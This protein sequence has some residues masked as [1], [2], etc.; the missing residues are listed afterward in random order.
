[1]NNTIGSNNNNELMC[2]FC[3]SLLE[4]LPLIK[5]DTIMYRCKVC[6]DINTDVFF[7]TRNKIYLSDKEL[8]DKFKNI[9][10]FKKRIIDTVIVCDLHNVTDLFSSEQFNNII[11]N[12]KIPVIILSFLGINT[13]MRKKTQKMINDYN[14]DMT[15]MC[16][17]KAYSNKP[18]TK[19]RF[20]SNILSN[21]KIKNVILLDD[22][23]INCLSANKGGGRCLLI[24][25]TTNSSKSIEEIKSQI[26]LYLRK[27]NNINKRKKF[28]NYINTAKFLNTKPITKK[29]IS[30]AKKS[31]VKKTKTSNI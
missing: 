17:K 18:G 10:S 19:G 23:E 29:N 7:D 25:T 4:V 27:L 13:V 2:D 1:M 5:K 31:K 21:N 20:I 3:G 15:F 8:Q 16:F 24:P 26:E 14:S 28:I 6:R 30:K 9:H 12:F 11:K 22:K